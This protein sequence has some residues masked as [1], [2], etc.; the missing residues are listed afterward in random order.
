MTRSSLA[1]GHRPRSR[2]RQDA[3]ATH[4]GRSPI[5][6]AR[7]RRLPAT[8][9]ISGCRPCAP[10][11]PPARHVSPRPR[12]WANTSAQD[13]FQHQHALGLS[14]DLPTKGLEEQ[15]VYRCSKVPNARSRVPEHST[16][17]S[18]AVSRSKRPPPNATLPGRSSSPGSSRSLTRSAAALPGIQGTPG[19]APEHAPP[20]DIERAQE[21][22][23]WALEWV[24]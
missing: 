3:H 11:R 1:H 17:S 15:P 20:S 10:S 12:A 18:F 4:R 21:L 6:A 2:D 24:S 23:F 8:A 19:S 14:A 22:A 5:P 7:S 16:L 13:P 9:R